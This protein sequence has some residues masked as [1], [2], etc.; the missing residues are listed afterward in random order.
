MK[1]ITKALIIFHSEV[2]N[3]AK[4][5]TN[6]YFKSKYG[7]L[8]SYLSVIKEPLQKAGLSFSQVMIH[9]GLKTIISHISGEF[10]ESVFT[11]ESLPSDVQKLGAWFTYMRRYQLSA[12]LGLNAEDNDGNDAIQPVKQQKQEYSLQELKDKAELMYKSF[13]SPSEKLKQ[14]IAQ[15]DTYDINEIKSGLNRMQKAIKGVK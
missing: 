9:N 1:E 15:I 5:S 10:I 13:T 8:N 2:G 6:P 12:I 7:D 14:W 3:V 11:C 4:N